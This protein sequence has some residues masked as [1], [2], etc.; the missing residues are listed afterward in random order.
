M[1][2]KTYPAKLLLFGEHTVNTG[3]QAL[4]LPLPLFSAKWQFAPNLD[5]GELAVRQMQL[6]Q[7]ADYLEELQ[8][9][10]ELLS[11]L[12]LAAF[13]QAL[14][15]GLVFNSDIPG[16]YGA[17]SSGALTA[18]VFETWTEDDLSWTKEPDRISSEKLLELKKIL[19]QMEAFFHGASSGTDPLVCFLQKPILLRER[20]E[21][22]L[23]H[24]H[25]V[26]MPV[27]L[28]LL[29]T[30]I[31]RRASPLIEYFLEKN[32]QRDFQTPCRKELLPAVNAA[33]EAFLLGRGERL[34]EE[35][36]RISRFQFL[37]LEK[38]IPVEFRSV[39]KEGLDGD[40]F[41][42]KICGAG[43]GGFLLGVAKDFQETKNKLAAYKLLPVW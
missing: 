17:G 37:F 21:L 19:A 8:K 14:K 26:K 10:G 3:S 32:R 18:A 33:I 15:D 30:G 11:R 9:R 36:H 23:A 12:N 1:K 16:G 24:L 2:V 13:R 5:K 35:I 28:F 29:D 39:W 20:G 4:A 41:K 43:G 7:F 40:L 27:T 22:Q 38:L 42:L 31:E 6:P 34:F 25:Q